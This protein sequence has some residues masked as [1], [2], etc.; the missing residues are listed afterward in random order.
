MDS[1]FFVN[2]KFQISAVVILAVIAV[3]FFGTKRIKLYSAGFFAGMLICAC[4]NLAFDIVTVYTISHIDTV[5][6]WLNRLAHQL[7]IGSI[8]TMLYFM[9]MYVAILGRK[10]RRM[11]KIYFLLVSVPYFIAMGFVIFGELYY[12]VDGNVVYS[13]GPMVYALYACAAAYMLLANLRVLIHRGDY[14]KNTRRALLSGTGFWVIIAITQYNFPGVLLSGLSVAVMMLHLYLSLEDPSVHIDFAANCFNRRAFEFMLHERLGR[15][16]EFVIV[17]IVVDGMSATNAKFGFAAT[18]ALLSEMSDALREFSGT[19]VCHYRG[20]AL[21]FMLSGN[22]QRACEVASL[23]RGRMSAPWTEQ[24]ITLSGRFHIDVIECPKY[25]DSLDGICKLLDYMLEAKAKDTI[26]IAGVRE[27][28][29]I[30][31]RAAVEALV[32]HAIDFDGFEVFYQP[33][34]STQA[35]TFATAEALLRLK[36]DKTI[37]YVPP[38]EFI[39]CAERRGHIGRIGEIVL[40]KVCEMA[41]R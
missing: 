1:A 15:R 7:F 2:A 4:L 41:A 6:A 34:F 26:R 28:E 13:Y 35:R 21:L 17:N 20:N 40:E 22:S 19:D 33:I 36:D 18:N 37:G 29:F 31:R 8:N 23:V 24:R 5:P 25:G 27:L 38:D 30:K 32:E 12:L 11:K 3:N 9:Y 39:L 10:E 16:K 14:S